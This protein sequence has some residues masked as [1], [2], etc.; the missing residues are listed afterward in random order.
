MRISAAPMNSEPLLF[1]NYAPDPAAWD[2]LFEAPGVAHGYC[3]LLVER[4]GQL[5][6]RE[7]LN[8]RTSADL[9]F[10]DPQ[11]VNVR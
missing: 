7:F 11:L 8:R 6:R 4:L 3:R 5:D 2:E 1:E 10:I 9:A